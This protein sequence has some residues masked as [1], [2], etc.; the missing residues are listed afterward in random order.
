V[1]YYVFDDLP[2]L[3]ERPAFGPIESYP[4]YFGTVLFALEAV[5]VFIALEAN[6]EKPKNFGTSRAA[7]CLKNQLNVLSIFSF[8]VWCFEF[9]HDN[10]HNLVWLCRIF[11]VS[12][13]WRCLER[14][15]HS[16]LA[17][18]NVSVMA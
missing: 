4:L 5:G 11:R 6:M 9:G 16:Q 14:Q 7:H 12:Q 13:I 3:S 2:S 15:H 10:C 18:W 17:R 8:E 1:L